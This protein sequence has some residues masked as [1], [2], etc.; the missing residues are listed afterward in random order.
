LDFNQLSAPEVLIGVRFGEGHQYLRDLRL[1][2]ST[3]KSLDDEKGVIFFREV[4]I[5]PCADTV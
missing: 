2:R 1:A 3:N 4:I 5:L